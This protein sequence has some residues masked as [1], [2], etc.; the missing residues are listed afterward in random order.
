ML[1]GRTCHYKHLQARW[2]LQPLRNQ[3]YQM[4]KSSPCFWGWHQQK[5]VANETH[6][7]IRLG[8]PLSQRLPWKARLKRKLHSATKPQHF[9][10]AFLVGGFKPFKCLKPPPSFLCGFTFASVACLCASIAPIFLAQTPQCPSHVGSFRP[11]WRGTK[12]DLATLSMT[13]VRLSKARQI[14]GESPAL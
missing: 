6:R 5:Q 2:W 7:T 10:N 12:K 8:K 9:H 3:I 11:I 13:K 1:R 14:H 4:R